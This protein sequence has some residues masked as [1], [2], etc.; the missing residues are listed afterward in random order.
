MIGRVLRTG[1]SWL[2]HRARILG[3]G[4]TGFHSSRTTYKRTSSRPM[5]GEDW[6]HFNAAFAKMDEAF[7]ELRKIGG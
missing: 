1:L 2:R 4:P 7:D 5:T 6:K 3:L